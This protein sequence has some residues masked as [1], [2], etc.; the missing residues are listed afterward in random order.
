MQIRDDALTDQVGGLDDTQ[1]LVVV[2]FDKRKLEP[3]FSG[4]HRN[5]PRFGR[6]I[7]AV[8]RLCFNAGKIYRLLQGPDNTIVTERS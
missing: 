5:G 1:H 2:V 7:Q 6:T 4:V 3:V 8:D